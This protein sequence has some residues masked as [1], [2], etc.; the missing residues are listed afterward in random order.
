MA[1]KKKNK[2]FNWEHKHLLGLRHLSAEEIS[3]IFDTA[4]GFEQISTR[5]IKKAPPLRGKVVVN[6][7]FED[8]TRTRN[9]F[10]LAASRLSADIIEFTQNY[11]LTTT[12]S[13]GYV[14]FEPGNILNNSI[15]LSIFGIIISVIMLSLPRSFFRTSGRVKKIQ[16]IHWMAIGFFLAILLFFFL[17]VSAWS[18]WLGAPI[19][20]VVVGIASFKFYSK[21][22]GLDNQS[23]KSAGGT[24]QGANIKTQWH[25]MGLKAFERGDMEQALEYIERAL[26]ESIE[27]EIIWNDKGHILRK[28]GRNS[29]ALKCFNLALKI[30][31]DYDIAQHN[32]RQTLTD[33]RRSR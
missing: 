5:S 13:T 18:I 7:F 27:D 20:T 19:F 31:P 24:A 23:V 15:I 14:S 21:V 2:R 9:S 4:E 10:A 30:N 6:L 28:L 25:K 17:G 3:Y 8:S 22:A 12:E 16:W 33:L 32:K 11:K 1:L 29:E 26:Q